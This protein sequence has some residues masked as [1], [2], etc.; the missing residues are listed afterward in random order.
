[1]LTA[2]AQFRLWYRDRRLRAGGMQSSLLGPQMPRVLGGWTI[3]PPCFMLTTGPGALLVAR[4]LRRRAPERGTPAVPERTVGAFSPS[5]GA[6]FDRSDGLLLE[7]AEPP[8]LEEKE[9]LEH[10]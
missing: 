2:S 10:K 1:M 4:Y 5:L 7:R 6:R 3:S 8:V 9:T